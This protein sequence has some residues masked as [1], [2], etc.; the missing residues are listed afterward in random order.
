MVRIGKFEVS[1]LTSIDSQVRNSEWVPAQEH[2]AQNVDTYQQGNYS[3]RYIAA[4]SAADSEGNRVPTAFAIHFKLHGPL[5]QSFMRGAD[6]IV[7][8]VFHD[9]KRIGSSHVKRKDWER[10]VTYSVR[11]SSRRYWLEDEGRWLRMKWH[12]DEGLHGTLKI[13]V[14]RQIE[15]QP[16]SG[17]WDA[18]LDLPTKSYGDEEYI[19]YHNPVIGTVSSNTRVRFTQR[20]PDSDIPEA[21]F[22]FEYRPEGKVLLCLFVVVLTLPKIR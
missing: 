6:I 5:S 7:F 4:P 16:H 1:V 15:S 10:G 19:D 2:T 9:N 20:A 13:Q 22:V 14:W 21:E 3:V 8:R 12:F 17:A 11:K 18:A